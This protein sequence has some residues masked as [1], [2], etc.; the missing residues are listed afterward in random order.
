MSEK[1]SPE[2]KGFMSLVN[3]HST[4]V[5][6]ICLS[7]ATIMGSDAETLEDKAQNDAEIAQ[8]NF[9][10]IEDDDQDCMERL[11]EL[12]ITAETSDNANDS[13]DAIK[14]IKFYE[15]RRDSLHKQVKVEEASYKKTEEVFKHLE[16][17][18]NINDF[19]EMILQISI[20]FS[21]VG[22]SSK[23][24]FLPMLAALGTVVGIVTLAV[25]IFM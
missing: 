6:A 11:E 8:Q 13:L 20:L 3:E 7:I 25:S 12:E 14:T 19:A 4:I 22:A 24:K 5:I 1:E 15:H 21:A 17:K 9:K 23:K 18:K 2:N 16:K 10:D